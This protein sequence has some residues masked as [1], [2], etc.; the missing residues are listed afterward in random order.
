M[1]PGGSVPRHGCVRRVW[2]CRGNIWGCVQASPHPKREKSASQMGLLPPGGA[3]A[4]SF[5]GQPAS[6]LALLQPKLFLVPARRDGEQQLRL[7]EELGAISPL[8]KPLGE[9]FPQH[10]VSQEMIFPTFPAGKLAPGGRQ[11]AEPVLGE[12]QQPLGRAAFGQRR[13]PPQVSFLGL[14]GAPQGGGRRGAA[15]LIRRGAAGGTK[16]S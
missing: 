9:A 15:L 11:P 2:S 5:T 1:T 12:L 4:R 10:E 3:R 14:E 7:L 16:S 8:P 6:N 13:F